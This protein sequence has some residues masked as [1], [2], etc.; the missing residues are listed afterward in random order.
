MKY[1]WLVIPAAAASVIAEVMGGVSFASSRQL[2]PSS[3]LVTEQQ[4]APSAGGGA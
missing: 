3:F 1:R 4:T 2:E